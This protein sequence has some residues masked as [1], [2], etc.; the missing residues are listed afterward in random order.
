MNDQNEC[1]LLY[2]SKSL[3]MP[4]WAQLDFPHQRRF[5]EN[6]FHMWAIILHGVALTL[7]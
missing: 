4:M 3:Q 5:N 7:H 2:L 6:V 1:L